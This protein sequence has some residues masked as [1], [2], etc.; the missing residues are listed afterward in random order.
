MLRYTAG[1]IRCLPC[2]R[3]PIVIRLSQ[4]LR[5]GRLNQNRPLR[6]RLS[7]HIPAQ[8]I[9][10]QGSLVREK[11]CLFS[12]SCF[13][14][15]PASVGCS[16]RLALRSQSQC[17]SSLHFEATAEKCQVQR[18]AMCF[19]LICQRFCVWF[20]CVKIRENCTR[21]AKKVYFGRYPKPVEILNI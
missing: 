4:R 18:F 21:E 13:P 6:D 17:L 15:S 12:I 14:C 9:L 7:D 16:V 11:V 3:R 2:L 10:Y 19:Y 8:H 20:R 5:R 1:A